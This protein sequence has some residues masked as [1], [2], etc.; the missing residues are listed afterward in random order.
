MSYRNTPDR[1][2]ERSPAQIIFGRNLRDFLPAPISRY[3]AQPGWLLLKDDRERALRKR[4]LLNS[5]RLAVGTR[6]LK[7]L[8]VGDTVQVQ[9]QV[10]NHPSR[11][12]ITGLIVETRPFDQ[13]IVKVHGS[14]RLTT[15]NRKFLRDITPYGSAPSRPANPG[16]V[17]EPHPG[18]VQ[19]PPVHLRSTTGSSSC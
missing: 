7:P 1:D 6:E 10:G 16:P 4:A 18:R 15:Q 14:G 9:N 11:W 19:I 8:Q 3:K 5:A 17:C 12:D 13:Y 2:T